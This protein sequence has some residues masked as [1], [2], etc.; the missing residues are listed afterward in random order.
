MQLGIIKLAW[1]THLTQY[2]NVTSLY[3][4]ACSVFY[5]DIYLACWL[6]GGN[7]FH[8]APLSLFYRTVRC[9]TRAIFPHSTGST[10]EA[11]FSD[12]ILVFCL[13]SVFQFVCEAV[14]DTPQKTTFQ[15]A[16]TS[17]CKAHHL[18]LAVLLLKIGDKLQRKQLIVCADF[19]LKSNSG[20]MTIPRGQTKRGGGRW[21]TS[22]S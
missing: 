17:N 5:I 20:H 22:L 9:S 4:G 13:F 15:K 16:F 21:H 3:R 7:I 2:Q 19:M 14:C 12:L 6:R 10:K 11:V 1:V 18:F 8:I